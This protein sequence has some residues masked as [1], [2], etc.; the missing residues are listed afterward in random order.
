MKTHYYND[1]PTPSEGIPLYF[2]EDI[3]PSGFTNQITFLLDY[4]ARLKEKVQ[5]RTVV[6][7]LHYFFNDYQDSGMVTPIS[8]ILD[9]EWMHHTLFPNIIFVDLHDLP[10]DFTVSWSHVE[11]ERIGMD[12]TRLAFLIKHVNVANAL[13]LPQSDSDNYLYITCP[14]KDIPELPIPYVNNVL[15]LTRGLF[16]G[17]GMNMIHDESYRTFFQHVRFSYSFSLEETEETCLLTYHERNVIHLR[18]E[19]D[20]IH[21]WFDGNKFST[22]E[23][24]SHDLINKY[25]NKIK[26]MISKDSIS[27]LV[28]SKHQDNPVM[29]WMRA[30]GYPFFIRPYNHAIGREKNALEDM[31]LA[32]TYGN[33]LLLGYA[34]STF[35]QWLHLRVAHKTSCFME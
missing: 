1:D 27:I 4:L 28:T 15:R 32:C 14:S 19:Q 3:R 7:F 8:H 16:H 22:K 26:E 6:V 9:L 10:S 2:Y 30:H 17:I 25:T 29:E 31:I 33:N 5:E 12:K 11:G 20:A 23:D 35:S 18:L 13:G 34:R 21:E 24:Y